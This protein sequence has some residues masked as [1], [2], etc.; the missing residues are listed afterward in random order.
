MKHLMILLLTVL[1]LAALSTTT[2][3]GAGNRTGT[4]G[5]TELLIP[6]GTRDI[7]MGGSTI[8]TTNGVEAL[9]YNPAGTAKM[10]NSVGMYFSHMSY[11]ADI[12]V[13]YGAV[14]ANF[15]GLGVLS[16]S[17]KSLS[18][19]DISETTTLAPDGTGKTFSPQYFT[20]GLT[21]AR[22][23]SDRIAVGLTGNLVSE[24]MGEVSAS[25]VAFNVGV[26]YENMGGVSGL[27]LG[28]V[29]KNIGPQMTFDGAGLYTQASVATVNRGPTLYK[30]EA[31]SFE[32]PSTLEFG[33]GYRRTF[34]EN[35]VLLSTTFQNNNYSDDE[36]KVGAEYAYQDILFL[37]GGMGFSQKQSETDYIYGP[38]FGAGVHYMVGSIDLTFDYAFRSVDVFDN[39][40]IFSLKL[41]F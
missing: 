20:V 28:V 40:H 6:V 19:G 41:G 38:T 13:D 18:I 25:G 32:L 30:I 11:I 21:Y 4:S 37:R 22:Q 31:G 33:V 15:E 16:V 2:F 17:I 7:A 35:T 26:M 36:Y 29:V 10:K 39:N 27:S 14:S 24:R 9:F 1:L 12:G 23:L 5:A 8:A 34:E 3:A